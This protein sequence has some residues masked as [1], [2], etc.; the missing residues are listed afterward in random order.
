MTAEGRQTILEFLKVKQ[1]PTKP[2]PNWKKLK[3]SLL[4][5]PALD[6]PGPGESLSK[7]AGFHAVLLKRQYDLP[8]GDYP[9]L[10][11]AKAE[12]LR[13]MLGMGAKEKITLETVQAALLKKELGDGAP[14]DLKKVLNRLLARQ[15]RARR[16]D[17]KELRDEVLRHW[18]DRSLGIPESRAEPPPAP[19]FDLNHF[20]DRVVTAARAC[21]T[22]RHGDSKVF[23]VHVWRMLRDDPEFRGTDFPTFK[24]R[25]AEA[26]N[27]R[28]LDLS[29]ADL[30]QAMDPEDVQLSEVS[31]LNASFHFIRIDPER[32]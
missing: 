2:K 23:I 16:D 30:V 29:R 20:A 24:Q 11:Q 26:N 14:T 15:L 6:L 17:T 8:L 13:K 31:Y 32:R 10:K 27:A 25:L 4:M 3:H 7:E 22:G 18:V 9:T 5:A 28:L 21:P 19:P 1:L 12:W